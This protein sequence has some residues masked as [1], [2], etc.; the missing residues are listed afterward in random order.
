MTCVC[1]FESSLFT[2]FR[3]MCLFSFES[4]G[5]FSFESSKF[6]A[7]SSHVHSLVSSAMCFGSIESCISL[8][9]E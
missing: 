3:V 8:C 4:V 9:F 6:Y 7:V 1:S 2:A 5:I